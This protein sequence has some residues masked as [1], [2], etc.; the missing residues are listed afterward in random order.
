MMGYLQ[1]VWENEA[2]VV[3]LQAIAVFRFIKYT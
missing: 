1:V 2:R 3:K